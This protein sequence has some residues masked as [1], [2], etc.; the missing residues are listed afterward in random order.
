MWAA[1][2]VCDHER[3]NGENRQW[4]RRVQWVGGIGA[5]VLAG[6]AVVL[7]PLAT[8]D[9][10]DR[11][12]PRDGV[13]SP[14]ATPTPSCPDSGVLIMPGEVEAAMG[15]RV[16]QIEMVNCGTTP[17]TV[18]GYPGVRVLDGER[19]PLT[20]AVSR[21]SSAISTIASFEAAPKPVTLQPGQEAV[22]GLVW[23]NTVT[24]ATVPASNGKYVEVA[25]ADGTPP[26]VIEAALDLG[27]TGKLGVAP[28]AARA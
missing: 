2:S 3:V 16:M 9:D 4:V 18:H 1:Q 24:D 15:L 20:V 5:L 14:T 21:G 7:S 26:Q 6:L 25:A 8:D 27:T 22:A 19:E 10:Q 23:R 17:Y 12:S 13:P 28:W 11:A